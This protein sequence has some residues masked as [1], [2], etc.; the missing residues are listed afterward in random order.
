M[1]RRGGKDEEELTWR[2]TWYE[3]L[4]CLEGGT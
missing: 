3:D 2:K 1:K 4:V